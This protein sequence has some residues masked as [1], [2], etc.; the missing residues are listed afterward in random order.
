MDPSKRR[1]AL[2]M[3]GTSA[4]RKVSLSSGQAMYDALVRLGCS[5]QAVDVTDPRQ[6]PARL[7]ADGI[8][9]AVIAL[10][11]AYGED[12]ALQGLL[13]WMAIPYTGSGVK[14]SAICMDKG[15]SKRVFRDGGLLTPPWW[16]LSGWE[17]TQ[18]VGA[19]HDH[20]AAG[21]A[22]FV[23]PACSGSSVG[24]SRVTT[25]DELRQ[26]LACAAQDGHTKP[27]AGAALL[28]EEEIRGAEVTLSVLNGQPLPLVEIRPE[29]GFYDYMNKYTCGRSRYLS[30]PPSL[31]ES[32]MARATEAG[33]QAGT[34]AGCRGLY[35]VDMIVD[36]QER[37]WILEINT[38][39][40]MTPLSLAPRAALAAGLS[41]DALTQN[42]M[43][44]AALQTCGE[45]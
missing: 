12:G 17:T 44:G 3:G 1:I 31:T 45:N 6:L 40:G 7:V 9:V 26:G 35:R 5:V 42:I 11:G 14:A 27:Q 37:V 32:A 2:L 25:R 36:D 19:L 21:R 10:H 43:M 30:P 22:L 16:E 4:E 24:I 23:K 39:P 29:E 13:E 38:I 8:E 15:M 33:L 41:F 18:E 34:L 28:V 20:L